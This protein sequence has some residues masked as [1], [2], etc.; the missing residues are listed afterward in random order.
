MKTDVIIGIDIG[1]TSTKTLAYDT[2]GAIWA[3]VEQEYPLYSPDPSWKE[4]D[5]EEIYAAVKSTLAEVAQQVESKQ[6]HIAGVGFSAAMHS[7]LALDDEGNVLTNALTWADQRSFSEAEEL[8]EGEG[9]A[10]YLRTGTPIHPMS[11]LTKLMWFRRNRPELFAK[12][13]KW[14]SL[15][16]YVCYRLFHRFIVDYSI[17]SATGLFNLKELS[18]DDETLNLVGIKEN[19]LSQ[20]VSTTHVVKGLDSELAAYLN[21]DPE[22][23]FVIGA[24]DGVLAN[25]GVGAVE[26]G[27]VACSIGTSGAI[28]TIVNEPTVDPK[29][30]IFCYAL[31]EDQWVI[32]G[33]I[34]NGGISF[35]W[36]RD[37]LF[38]DIKESIKPN[39]F[40]AYDELTRRAS[41]VRPGSNGLLFLPYLTGERAPFWDADTKGVFFGLTLDHGRDHMVRSVLEGVMF[42]MYSVAI[43]LIEA[44]VEP[45]EYRAGGGFARSELWRQIMADIFETEIVVPESHQGSCL[46]AAWLSMKALGMIDDL[47]S[48]KE[49]IRTKVKHGPIEENVQTYR[50]LKPVFLRLARQL[51]DEFKAISEVQRKISTQH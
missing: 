9:H 35:R 31:T 6:G 2:K 40:T 49:V 46:G 19:Q 20:P 44:G 8:K 48:V 11:P 32:G 33:P 7:I 12:A 39:G 18:W 38:P 25:I 14:I 4:Q 17:A 21:L 50:E 13:T 34:N 27:S 24:S 45:V 42:Q 29:G 5:P 16:E 41:F 51:P 1:T 43:A 23:P 15:K 37:Q 30:R 26:H 22:T 47:S 28:R 10:I 36:A 3:E